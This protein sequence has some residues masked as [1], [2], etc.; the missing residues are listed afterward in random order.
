M[1]D[2]GG[3][4]FD[5]EGLLSIDTSG[6]K[7]IPEEAQAALAQAG[8]KPVDLVL[9]VQDGQATAQIA[10]TK[11]ELAGLSAT[12][13]NPKVQL[14]AAQATRGLADLKA[15]FA[16]NMAAIDQTVARTQAGIDKLK[17][18][19]AGSGG[20]VAE[21]TTA[22]PLG[23]GVSMG[24]KVMA[25]SMVVAGLGGAAL[26]LKSTTDAAAGA[27][28]QTEG[29]N[30]A[31]AASGEVMN[32][33]AQNLSAATG[34]QA[35][36]LKQSEVAFKGIADTVPMTNAQL[37]QLVGLTTDIANTSA[38]PQYR[39]NIEGVTSALL[40][41]LQ[42]QGRGMKELGIDLDDVYM[43]STYLG[44]ALKDTWATMT[45]TQKATERL[46]AL[47]GQTADIQG[48]AGR[49]T[50]DATKQ[51]KAENAMLEARIALGNALLPILQT[52][53]T[54]IAKTPKPLLEA[55][56]ILGAIA[57][58]AVPAAMAV[59]MMG[60][61]GS[62]GGLGRGG[63][64]GL[65]A[66]ATAE[67]ETAVA[68]QVVGRGL[69]ASITRALKTEVTAANFKGMFSSI[70]AAG[71]ALVAEGG[72]AKI[73]GQ[74]KALGSVSIGTLGPLTLIAGTVAALVAYLKHIAGETDEANNETGKLIARGTQLVQN[75]AA[76][77]TGMGDSS[78]P[79]Q[80]Q[81]VATD[82]KMLNG[83]LASF[84]AYGHRLSPEAERWQAG[85]E[86][87]GPTN[88]EGDYRAHVN[89]NV[90]V[91]PGSQLDAYSDS[92]SAY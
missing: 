49:S 17:G 39:D 2:S 66:A 20:T 71:K 38:I 65:A 70:G 90:T 44:G 62:I 74:I 21:T 15:E 57:A 56:T 14:D 86:R 28:R 33:Y 59:S 53:N 9:N 83:Q 24:S 34:Y 48:A 87:L 1:S 29:V 45:P 79:E 31:F 92:P 81:F 27:V 80:T 64:R 13:A 40:Q 88:P 6:L 84:N 3:R 91:P 23:G 19:G 47:F 89:I 52:V 85:R 8:A 61:R 26:V 51:M 77:E 41:S 78:N 4:I 37:Q 16:K 42:G 60:G 30:R 22:A 50:S 68:G 11:S 12:T 5:L 18:V 25:G 67:T 75:K 10:S 72:L 76:V 82:W 55:A 69:T 43:K 63:A 7:Q 58:V 32:K 35:A 36:L 54:I 46:N 73:A